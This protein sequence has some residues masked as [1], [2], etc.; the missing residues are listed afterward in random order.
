[1]IEIQNREFYE[2]SKL[3]V[4]AA[5]NLLIVRVQEGEKVPVMINNKIKIEKDG[6]WK[7][8]EEQ[9]PLFVAILLRHKK[10][11]ENLPEYNECVKAM[12]LDPLISKYLNVPIGFYNIQFTR[13]A[14]DYLEYLVHRQLPSNIERIEFNS[15]LFDDAY[16][17]LERFFY[18]DYLVMS[19][20]SPLHNFTAEDERIDLDG[21]LC[22]RKIEINE[23]EQLINE[24][25]MSSM[26]PFHD[27]ASFKY[28][29]ELQL[30]AKKIIGS[31]LDVLKEQTDVLSQLMGESISRLVTTLRLFKTGL[32][33]YNIVRTL[34]SP[35]LPVPFGTQTSLTSSYKRFRGKE[36]ILT[37][38]E[39]AEL[40]KLWEAINKINFD[41]FPQL[42]I[43]L[44]RFNFAY[45]RDKLEDKLIDFMVAFEALFF[46]E[47]ETGE[48]RHKLAVRVSR[49]LE[50]KYE[51]RK[52]VVDKMN[53]F[54]NERS[55]VVHGEK[56][57]LKDDFI[58]SVEDHL[59]KSIVIFLERLRTFDHGEIISR[60][61]L[62]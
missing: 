7:T 32:V 15:M 16:K 11:L 24:L 59:R 20:I 56:A 46:K 4:I 53:K 50:Q 28:T 42:S 44:S 52:A 30:Q 60:L 22:I 55:K 48:F 45:E 33:G 25:R 37:K 61:D 23:Q 49:L 29:I 54:Y 38:L 40:G 41:T 27:A 47:G 31:T 6:S 21:N 9:A 2:K 8:I 3:F 19:V 34:G 5:L 43:A 1:M 51:N 12:T 39:A 36:Y 13:T 57:D 10:D 35:E 62:E 17:T 14:Q 18:Q 26:M 58:N